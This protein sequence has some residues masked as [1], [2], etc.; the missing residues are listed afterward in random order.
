MKDEPRHATQKRPY[1]RKDLGQKG[2]RINTFV[3]AHH[4]HPMRAILT[5]SSIWVAFSPALAGTIDDCQLSVRVGPPAVAVVLQVHGSTVEEEVGVPR[6]RAGERTWLGAAARG[7]AF[8]IADGVVQAV[9]EPVGLQEIF[10]EDVIVHV[11]H[12]KGVLLEVVSGVGEVG[13]F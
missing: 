12:G 11:F 13:L 3:E 10:A 1:Q 4:L 6:G 7:R 2:K 8:R 5:G 9:V